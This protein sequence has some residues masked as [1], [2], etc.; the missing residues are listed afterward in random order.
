MSRI[1][2]SQPTQLTGVDRTLQPT[3]VIVPPPV[4]DN[5]LLLGQLARALEVTGDTASEY[6]AY[7]GRLD[8]DRRRAEAERRRV[9]A[10][11]K[12]LHAGQGSLAGRSTL[13]TL[14]DKIDRR[15]PLY[16][17]PDGMEPQQWAQHNAD[18]YTAGMP[19]AFKQSFEREFVPGFIHASTA[20]Q[21]QRAGEARD[22]NLE[23]YSAAIGSA[24]SAEEADMIWTVAQQTYGNDIGA[25]ALADKVLKPALFTAA[26]ANDPKRVDY[27]KAQLG[28][29]LAPEQQRADLELQVAKNRLE[30]QTND[31][32][33]NAL[34]D[35]EVGGAGFDAR[36]QFARNYPGV[37]GA[38]RAQAVDHIASQRHTYETRTGELN[39]QRAKL[40]GKQDA[41]AAAVNTLET[42]QASGGAAAINEVKIPLPNG[43]VEKYPPHELQEDAA[44]AAFDRIDQKIPGKDPGSLAA[45]FNAKTDLLATSGAPYAP[46]TNKMVTGAGQA[47]VQTL[48]MQAYDD[49]GRPTGVAPAKGVT[50]SFALYDQI[51]TANPQLASRLLGGDGQ[52][53]LFLATAKLAKD[54]VTGGDANLALQMAVRAVKDPGVFSDALSRRID[55]RELATNVT[56]IKGEL[57]NRWNPFS[58]K[59]NEILNPQDVDRNVEEMARFAMA[60]LSMD[61][62]G[63]LKWAKQSTLDNTAVLNGWAVNTAGHHV[64]SDLGSVAA[65]LAVEYAKGHQAEEVDPKM[66]TLRPI[67]ANAWM[68]VHQTAG[69]TAPVADYQHAIYTDKDLLDA[70]RGDRASFEASQNLK[71]K[72]NAVRVQAEKDYLTK[73]NAGQSLPSMR[74]AYEAAHHRGG[75]PP[76][77]EG[78]PVD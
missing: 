42:A 47:A 66:L 5:A 9:D 40:V 65:E 77:P 57:T 56:A 10:D 21:R 12:E 72:Q 22:A 14:Q 38:T 29:M 17:I 64:P 8:T 69:T 53:R 35:L 58:D 18:A 63:A 16:D 62:A 6:S 39:L 1:N 26:S 23:L 37:D 78:T 75:M 44:Q 15:D 67:G 2:R 33:K 70:S 48:Y 19:E 27:I 3:Q 49:K 41:L 71:M 34:G 11:A 4:S 25:V 31:A 52:A 30:A 60:A 68:M 20:S 55:P 76:L 45:N 74:S 24:Q 61:E 32:F 50:D 51:A 46:W 59:P 43:T 54:R 36:E 28:T 73:L 13:A 7:Q